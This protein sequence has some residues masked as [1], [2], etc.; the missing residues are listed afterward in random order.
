MADDRSV[1]VR[2]HR[3]FYF[4]DIP[5]RCTNSGDISV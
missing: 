3:V 2:M 4:R 5:L 1:M